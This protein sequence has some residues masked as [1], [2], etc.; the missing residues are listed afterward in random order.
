MAYY[1][2]DESCEGKVFHVVSSQYLKDEIPPISLPLTPPNVIGGVSAAVLLHGEMTDKP[3]MLLAT[4]SESELVDSISLQPFANA[5]KQGSLKKEWGVSKVFE[6]LHLSS[7]TFK[8]N[9]NPV[10]ISNLYI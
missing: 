10:A 2:G 5:I 9:I 7:K 4:Y 6:Q 1:Q 8:T 3:S